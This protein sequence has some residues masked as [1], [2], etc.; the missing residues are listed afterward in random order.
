MEVKS[1]V[2]YANIRYIIYTLSIWEINEHFIVKKINT[3]HFST[4]FQSNTMVYAKLEFKTYQTYWWI[5]S[6]FIWLRRLEKI[7][8]WIILNLKGCKTGDLVVA[9]PHG[10]P[11]HICLEHKFRSR[12]DTLN[13]FFIL[14]HEKI[15]WPN[16]FFSPNSQVEHTLPNTWTLVPS[17]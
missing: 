14:T 11:I 17:S 1:I 5:T 9:L 4:S 10:F 15:K 7:W 2:L 8:I 3:R 6:V 16:T 13:H 12:L